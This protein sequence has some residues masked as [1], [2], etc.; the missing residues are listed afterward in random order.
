M[1]GFNHV[2]R[3][4]LFFSEELESWEHALP[5]FFFTMGFMLYPKHGDKQK[6]EN[7]QTGVFL[8]HIKDRRELLS[9][10]PPKAL[11]ELPAI[12]T[13]A[14]DASKTLTR[15]IENPRSRF[16]LFQKGKIAGRMGL[17]MLTF[18][19]NI[20]AVYRA[21]QTNPKI[22]GE[23]K[24]P[25]ISTLQKIWQEDGCGF[26]YSVNFW[27]AYVLISDDLKQDLLKFVLT[28]PNE[29]AI[30]AIKVVLMR[31]ST[32]YYAF[33][34]KNGFSPVHLI[35]PMLDE[36]PFPRSTFSISYATTWETALGKGNPPFYRDGKK[37]YCDQ[38]GLT[39][40]LEEQWPHGPIFTKYFS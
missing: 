16:S 20:A 37:I 36:K 38:P 23:K 13:K 25:S 14:S 3:T 18:S 26:V 21:V 31:A 24:A 11:T 33:L 1:A 35:Q 12:L 4:I 7:F 28:A 34:K 15:T 10:L 22:I 40:H 2:D 27:A 6:A 8:E 30:K 19:D 39:F 5:A 9:K 29:D 32:L 17:L